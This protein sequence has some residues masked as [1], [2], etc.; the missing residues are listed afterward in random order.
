M[1]IP[2][3]QLCVG[4]VA[5][6]VACAGCRFLAPR[7]SETAGDATPVAVPTVF[8]EADVRA[9]LGKA[10]A[11]LWRGVE[12]HAEHRNCF[13]CHN[14][15][16]TILAFATA[17][18]RGV[19]VPEKDFADLVEFSAAYFEGNR[20]QFLTGRGP[21]PLGLG[22]ATDTTGWGLFALA[23]AGNGPDATTAAVVEYTLG[24][25]RDRDHWTSWGPNRPPAEGS[26]F[27]PTALAVVGLQA[28]AQPEHRERVARRVAAARGWLTATP[29]ATAE[30]RVYRLIGLH[31]AG[32]DPAETGRAAAE[33]GLN[34]RADGGW[35]QTAAMPTDAYATASA[36]AAL[37]LAG[38]VPADDPSF[39]RG[40][41]YLLRTQLADGSWRVRSHSFRVQPYYESGFPHGRDQFISAA[42]TGWAATAL[43]LALPESTRLAGAPDEVPHR[44]DPV[45]QPDAANGQQE[46]AVPARRA[47]QVGP[48][49]PVGNELDGRPPRADAPRPADLPADV[50]AR[51]DLEPGRAH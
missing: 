16:T 8:S 35:G 41:A 11:V 14:H 25:D 6:A 13:T 1:R 29:A 7:S 2:L 50:R 47:E 51:L 19:A 10:H 26:D 49:L 46:L 5:L 43:A 20:E 44:P 48:S 9:A 18:S 30:D 45:S 22:G 42:A 38:G 28:F 12:G 37:R 36:L 24:R 21:G 27:M 40:V 23:T 33:I 4:W 17:R 39:R 31:A 3:R 32:A 15:G 34:Q